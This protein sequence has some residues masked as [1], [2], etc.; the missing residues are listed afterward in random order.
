MEVRQAPKSRPADRHRQS[1]SDS[2]GHPMPSQPAEAAG[3]GAQLLP[4][5]CGGLCGA[6]KRRL[7]NARLRISLRLAASHIYPDHP[8]LL[9]SG[10]GK[11]FVSPEQ[12]SRLVTLLGAATD[13]ATMMNALAEVT[14]EVAG[15]DHS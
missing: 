9:L 11:R 5:A 12:Q 4:G 7:T 15:V 10:S 14:R 8:K 6:V 1:R 3:F 13:H 2:Q